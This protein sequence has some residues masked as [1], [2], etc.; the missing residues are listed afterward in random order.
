MVWER[1]SEKAGCF[2]HHVFSYPAPRQLT[3]R[4]FKPP[5]RLA[6]IYGLRLKF[7]PTPSRYPK[8]NTGQY[9]SR[10]TDKKR[11]PIA[12]GQIVKMPSQPGSQ[13]PS[14][15]I[16]DVDKAIDAPKMFS[17]K[18]I[19]HHGGHDGTTRSK[20]QSKED[21]VKVEPEYGF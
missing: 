4:V 13:C 7:G 16:S 2:F 12:T 11:N 14:N 19:G 5:K 3:H 21:G 15:P 17:R 20:S 1:K 9:K 10:N 6:G 18:H 8:K